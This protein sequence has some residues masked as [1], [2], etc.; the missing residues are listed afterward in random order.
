MFK[1]SDVVTGLVV[2]AILTLA[3]SG[4]MDL[5]LPT[6]QG[7]WSDAIRD[8]IVVLFGHPWEEV[9]AVQILVGFA[10]ILFVTTI[11]A[12]IGAFFSVMIFTFFKKMFHHIEKREEE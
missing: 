6:G 2:G 8:S 1:R 3:I 10:A 7:G 5:F 4:S 9:L 12:L 11:G